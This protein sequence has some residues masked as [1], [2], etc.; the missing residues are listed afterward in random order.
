[1]RNVILRYV[2]NSDSCFYLMKFL[3]REN[4]MLHLSASFIFAWDVNGMLCPT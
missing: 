4:G 1:M 2:F 3:S